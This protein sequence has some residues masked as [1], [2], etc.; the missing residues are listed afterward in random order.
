MIRLAHRLRRTLVACPIVAG[1]ALAGC[2]WRPEASPEQD[3]PAL[4]EGLGEASFQPTTSLSEAKRYFDQGL[5]LTYGFNHE[6]AA[7]S[8]EHAT[9]L[10][11]GCAA[12]FWGLALTLGPN[13]N[14]PMG[15]EAGRRAYAAVQQ[16]HELASLG[17]AS[18]LERA[19]IQALRERYAAEPPRDRSALDRAYAEAMGRVHARFPDDVDVATL[20]A[21]ALMDLTPWDYWTDE[22]E[23]REHTLEILALLEAVQERMPGHVGAAH[24]YIHATE[25]FFPE[26]A[27]AAADRLARLAP[28]AGHLVHMPSHIYWRLGRYQDA[29][30]TNRRAIEADEA[31]FAACRPGAYYRAL[32]YPHNIHFLWAAAAAAG[33]SE[34]AI[35]AAR[36]LA[37]STQEKLDDFAF[38]EEFV[39]IPAYTWVR[40]GRWDEALG[41][42]APDPSRRY[43]SG[44]W[45]YARGMA[46]ARWGG[47]VKSRSELRRLRE[48]AAEPATRSQVIAG[49]TAPASKLL[50]IAAFPLEGELLASEGQTDRAVAAL[51]QA[52]ALQDELV[53]M[54]P[55]PFYFP[56]REALGAVLLEAG[57]AAEAE[58]VYRLDLE[59]YPESGWALFGLS[60]SLRAQGQRKQADWARRGFET[61][62]RGADVELTTSRF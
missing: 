57:R 18:E 6:A 42:P 58:A 40:F 23:P 25:E 10:D 15:P 21:E 53:Y 45:H 43:L 39:A 4:L 31:Y 60:Q 30:D 28:D 20:Y 34:L 62:W 48:I 12:C 1:L 29:L 47:F 55:P 36:K 24:Y 16:A 51:E 49:G 26:K 37:A 3:A 13:I 50:E 9:R 11:P 22:A 61:A 14:A 17:D 46:W 32:Y 19:L 2:A 41:M 5:A 38:L 52:V 7:R 8:F 33:Q 27:E 59:Q 44:A 56:V 35:G 54:E